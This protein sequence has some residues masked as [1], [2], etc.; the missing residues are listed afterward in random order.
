MNTARHVNGKPAF[1]ISSLSNIWNWWANSRFSS[2]IIGYGNGFSVGR[3]EKFHSNFHW[4]YWRK[5]FRF[6]KHTA[7]SNN[8]GDP[9]LMWGNTITRKGYGLNISALK[10][11]D[12]FCYTR[13]FCRANWSIVSRM[14]KQDTPAEKNVVIENWILFFAFSF[15][16]KKLT[17]HQATRK[18]LSGQQL[19]LLRN[20]GMCRQYSC[21]IKYVEIFICYCRNVNRRYLRLGHEKNVVRNKHES[22][23]I[24]KV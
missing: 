9:S 5:C 24:I 12:K 3:S 2:S 7:I 18:S 22:S 11:R 17:N 20:S 19:C 21:W 4:N 6:R 1:P 10:F 8:I 16:R 15:N 13:Q 14:R 23:V